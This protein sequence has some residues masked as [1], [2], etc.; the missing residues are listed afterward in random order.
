MVTLSK[1][2]VYD[3][4]KGFNR[5]EWIKWKDGVEKG[6][7]HGDWADLIALGTTILHWE[8]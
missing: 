4:V 2:Q 3:I 1:M 7:K 6:V 8:L 5:D